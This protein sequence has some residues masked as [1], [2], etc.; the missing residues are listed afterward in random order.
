MYV[1]NDARIELYISIIISIKIDN[2]LIFLQKVTV[3]VAFDSVEI[4]TSHFADSKRGRM[5]WIIEENSL[6]WIGQ[7][8]Y[9]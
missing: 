6:P 2:K 3:G 1:K 4:T 8:Y 7:Y 5:S 9:I